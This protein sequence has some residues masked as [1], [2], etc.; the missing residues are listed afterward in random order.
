MASHQRVVGEESI[1]ICSLHQVPYLAHLLFKLPVLLAEIDAD[2]ASYPIKLLLLV[3]NLVGR[4]E[5][6]LIF[7]FKV[8]LDRDRFIS[9]SPFFHDIA[10]HHGRH[11]AGQM[12]AEAAALI[13]HI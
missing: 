11:T 5:Y 7:V 4:Q 8:S 2:V 10:G 1:T 13:F 6:V 9:P 12:Q 3:L